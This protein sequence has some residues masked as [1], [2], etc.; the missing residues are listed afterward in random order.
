ME[1]HFDIVPAEPAV[2][3]VIEVE[4]TLEGTEVPTAT[5]VATPE[6]SLLLLNLNQKKNVKKLETVM[7]NMLKN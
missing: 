3:E 5:V 7:K 6:A 4:P 2:K 1:D